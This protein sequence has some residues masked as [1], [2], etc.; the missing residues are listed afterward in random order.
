MVVMAVAL[1][2]L[3]VVGFVEIVLLQ[4]CRYETVLLATHLPLSHMPS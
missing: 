2:Y 1:R 3:N 4:Y